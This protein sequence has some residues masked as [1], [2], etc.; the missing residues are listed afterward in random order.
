MKSDRLSHHRFIS[1]QEEDFEFSEDSIM[2]QDDGSF[3]IRGDAALEDVDSILH[4]SLAEDSALKEFATLSGFLCMCAGEIP[5]TG[6]LVMSRG[7]CFEIEHADDKRILLARVERLL[8]DEEVDDE[9]KGNPIRGFLR[10][11]NG[12]EPG[13]DDDETDESKKLR[14]EEM[15][16]ED[17]KRAREAN[18]AAAREVEAI[19]DSGKK[20]MSMLR[21]LAKDD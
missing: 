6:D 9:E 16:D 19:V 18:L 2:L 7:W 3:L 21:D 14:T 10:L 8:G 5:A 11:K 15:I 1:L 13:E 4:L 12:A 17:V 20:K